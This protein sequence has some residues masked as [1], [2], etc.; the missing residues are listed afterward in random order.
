MEGSM[1]LKCSI[2]SKLSTDS[3]QSPSKVLMTLQRSRIKKIIKS[4]FGQQE[5]QTS[6]S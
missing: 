1:L 5:D 4:A 3:M 6:Q 2:Y